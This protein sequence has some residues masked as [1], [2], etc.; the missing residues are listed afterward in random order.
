M[1]FKIGLAGKVIG[2]TSMHEEIYEMCKEYLTDGT[3]DFHV[4][5]SQADIEFEREKSIQEAVI[6]GIPPQDYPDDYLETLAVYRRIA[7]EMLRYDTM[8]MHG[9]VIGI[10]GDGGSD[11]RPESEKLDALIGV[12]GDTKG[13]E[14]DGREDMMDAKGK[15][16]LFTAQSG[17][18]KTTHL[19]LWLDQIPGAF[20]VNGD[21]PLLRFQDG[22]WQACGTPWAGKE[23]MQTNVIMPLSAICFLERGKQNEIERVPFME[24]YPLLF[25]QIY[26]S[27]EPESMI[28]TMELLKKIGGTVPLFRLR[29]NMEPEAA[30]V[31]F[32]GV[33]GEENE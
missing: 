26:R 21:K 1:E 8:L 12:E 17:V 2:I 5:T 18:G 3:E 14:G 25:Q 16:V 4:M 11:K 24:Y 32:H 19:R 7:V 30:R 13:A 28:K 6:E 22:N 15:A 10:R 33:F 27:P 9:A 23:G 20:V 29:C 31:A